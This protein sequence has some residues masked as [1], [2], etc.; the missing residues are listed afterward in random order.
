MDVCMLSRSVPAHGVGGMERHLHLLCRELVRLG[1]EV[2]V[3]TTSLPS[4]PAKEYC[5]TSEGVGYRFLAD[6]PPGRY[7]RSWWRASRKAFMGMSPDIV[8]SQSIGAFGILRDV[9]RRGLPLVASCHG[10]PLSDTATKIRSFG[11]RAN[12]ADLLATISK[13]PHHMKVYGAARRVIAVSPNLAE[14]LGAAGLVQRDR[15]TVVLNGIDTQRFSPECAAGAPPGRGPV[16]FSLARIVQEKGFQF[17]V[18][19]MP[20]IRKEHA[21]AR[22][23]VGGDGPYMAPLRSLAAEEGVKEAVDFTGPILED[24]LPTRYRSCDLFALATTHVEGLP[25]VLPE[26]LACGRPIAASRIGGIPDVVR[27]GSTGALFEPGNQESVT[28]TLLELLSDGGRLREM[29]KN[30][31]EDAVRRFG[32][33]RMARETADVY[34]TVI[35]TSPAQ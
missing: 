5:S 29:G 4:S 9:Q 34:N 28:R 35:G 19:A 27:E 6:C 22:L 8:H 21:A 10:T 14:H 7:S 18:R 15:I 31:R 24:D 17:L 12:P 26:A 3:L 32:A 11:L 1:H 2:S 33:A 16:I 20:A 25:L 30:A 13:L 23:V